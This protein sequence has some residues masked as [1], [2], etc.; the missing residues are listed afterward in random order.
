MRGRA[1]G[2]RGRGGTVYRVFQHFVWELL[3]IA[4]MARI[5]AIRAVFSI[6]FPSGPRI[7]PGVGARRQESLAWQQ[8]QRR[9]CPFNGVTPEQTGVKVRFGREVEA[10][11]RG[12]N[13]GRGS[14]HS[15]V[16]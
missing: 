12:V 3:K 2:P 4:E 13:H 7:H 15:K 8:W 6:S 1:V 11:H 9:R 16:I 5:G 14:I 10:F